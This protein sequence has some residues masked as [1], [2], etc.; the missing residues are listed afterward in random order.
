MLWLTLAGATAT[1]QLR[2]AEPEREREQAPEPRA[3]PLAVG[4]SVVP[5]A[6][7]HG[8]GH[9]VAGHSQT[10][11]R[12][13]LAEAVGLGLFLGGGTTIALTGA[14]RYV[15]GP[16]IATTVMGAGLF[17]SS[18]FADIYGT[19]AEGDGAGEPALRAALLESSFGLRYVE[20]PSL[21]SGSF[22]VEAFD[23]RLG[24]LRLVPS[25]W[26]SL[27][28]PVAIYRLGTS[29]RLYGA[30]AEAGAPAR[31]GTSFDVTIAGAQQRY[32][33]H[34]FTA[35]SGEVSLDARYDLE[36]VG[37][38]LRGSFVEAQLGYGSQTYDYA[39]AGVDVPSDTRSVLLARAGFGLYLGHGKRRGGEARIYYDHRHD[40]VAG[41]LVMYGLGSGA[42]GHF[43]ADGRVYFDANWGVLCEAQA[44]AAYVIG[45]SLL[46]RQ[47]AVQ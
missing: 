21:H 14:S 44:G 47:G 15:I 13:L 12:L 40:D 38:S 37:R 18:W 20:N 5:G 9:Y 46:F 42:L 30:L 11:G 39:A 17:L 41:G 22:L 45:A 6:I 3:D 36:R 10:G 31:D 29:F 24:R 1:G 8:A 26:L 2:A 35:T 32:D 16:A 25:A 19:A 7:V 4:A 27:E 34:G 33:I 43:G 28:E 23:L